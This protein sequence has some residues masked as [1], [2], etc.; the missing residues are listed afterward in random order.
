[1]I[2]PAFI[3]YKLYGIRFEYEKFLPQTSVLACVS[4]VEIS[5]KV[6]LGISFQS[7]MRS[8]EGLNWAWQIMILIAVSQSLALSGQRM[9][10]THRNAYVFFYA[11][12]MRSYGEHSILYYHTIVCT[13]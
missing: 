5:G 10:S 1:M 9:H 6:L 13:L 4:S 12:F 7:A 11:R 3:V 8:V 2:I